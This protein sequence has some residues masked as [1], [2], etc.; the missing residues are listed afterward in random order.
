[1]QNKI[2]KKTFAFVTMTLWNCRH[3]ICQTEESSLT[4]S[5]DVYSR[6]IL[7][8]ICKIPLFCTFCFLFFPVCFWCCSWIFLGF[9][10]SFL[11]TNSILCCSWIFPGIFVPFSNP[12]NGL[13]TNDSAWIIHRVS[14]VNCD[15]E[16][17]R[18]GHCYWGIVTQDTCPVCPGV[19]N[20]FPSRTFCHLFHAWFAAFKNSKFQDKRGNS[21]LQPQ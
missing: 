7:K 20:I 14:F 21:G 9:W 15:T 19:I 6:R 4:L 3:W 10:G 17:E 12:S 5:Q 2:F 13:T 1:M 11:Q 16:R 8:T 18:N